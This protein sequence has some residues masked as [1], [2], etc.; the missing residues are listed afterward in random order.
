[1]KVSIRSQEGTTTG[2]ILAA[3]TKLLPA[4]DI[5]YVDFD[6]YM[7]ISIDAIANANNQYWIDRLKGLSVH[8][9]RLEVQLLN[10]IA[11]NHVADIRKEIYKSPASRAADL[12]GRAM[13]LAEVNGW[14]TMIATLHLLGIHVAELEIK[15]EELQSEVALLKEKAHYHG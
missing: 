7:Y 5:D 11:W 15:V 14:P 10:D 1:M 13:D 12:K 2:E 8:G 6:G 3:L 9:R 4:E